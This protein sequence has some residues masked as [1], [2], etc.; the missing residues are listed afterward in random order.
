MKNRVLTF[1]ALALLAIPAASP[2]FLPDVPRTNDL[3]PHLFRAFFFDRAAEW[4]G[5]WPR[6]SPDLIY[7]YGYPVF[8]F[9]PSLFHAIT[10]TLSDFGLPLLTAYRV[11]TYLHFL[12]AAVGSYL[13]G[14]VALRSWAAG[15]AVALVYTYSPY[16]LYDAHVRG[17]A[18]ETQALALLP[19]LVLAIWKSGEGKFRISDFGFQRRASVGNWQ[20]A[21]DHWQ[22]FWPLATAVLFAATFISHPVVYQILIPMGLWL[23]LRAWFARK[24][25]RFWASL[26]GP[27]VGI[28]LG[29]LL[30]AFYWLPAFVEVGFVQAERSISQGYAHQ[31]NFLSLADML[32][33]PHLPAD[34]ALVNPPVVRALPLVGLPGRLILASRWQKMAR[35][36][37]EIVVTWTAVL[38]LCV[39]LITPASLFVWD[40]FPLLRLTFYPWR[41]LSMA[42]LATAILAGVA[43]GEIVNCELRIVNGERLIVN[44]QSLIVNFFLTVLIIAASIPWLYPPRQAMPERVDLPLA[45]REE[46]PPLF[47]GTT[48]LGE[49]LPQW[50]AELPPQEP[51]QSALIAQ[52]NP[53]RLQPAAGL[54]WTRQNENPVNAVYAVTATRPLTVTYGQFYFPGWRAW[55]DGDPRPITP[56]A[57]HGLI[58]IPVPEGDHEL[59]FAFGRTPARTAGWV[60]S[61]L[62]LAALLGMGYFGFR[63]SDFRVDHPKS[64]IP[65]PKFLLGLTAVLVWLFFT[66]VDTPLRRDTLLPDGV[67]GK[68]AMTPLDYAGELRLLTFEQSATAVAADEPIEL[69]LY[70]QPQREIGVP[71]DVGVQVLDAT[72]RQWQA[73]T[74]RPADWR[75]VGAEP[76]PLDSYRL[77]PF[78]VELADGTPPGDYTFHVGLVRGDTGQTVAAHDL[79]GFEVTRPANGARELE[80]GM[81][82]AGETAVARNLRLLGTRLDRDEAAPGD[83]ARVTALWQATAT[84][85]TPTNEFTL[86]LVGNGATV[87]NQPVTIAPDYPLADW[88][89]GDRLRSETILRL[90]A[91][92]ASGEYTWR[93]IWGDQDVAVGD[94]RVMAPERSFAPVAVETAVNA[95]FSDIATLLG[96]SFTPAPLLPH[97]PLLITLVWRAERET[98][99]SY[100]VFVHLIDEAGQ[101][102]AQSDGEPANWRRPTTGWLTGEIIVDEHV[103]TLP[104]SLP[105]GPLS[106]RIGLY[107]PVSGERLAADL[108]DFVVIPLEN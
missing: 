4:G 64:E 70:W 47:I 11:M 16:L 25:G 82:A 93:L 76:W 58:T 32:R 69:T 7:S 66:W 18:P 60:I 33:W 79:G 100:H 83:V 41:L 23:L 22:L 71:Y 86:Q 49:F 98:P 20:L 103:L 63:I 2:F 91:D 1:L 88:R 57:P 37:R 38:L 52:N 108:T 50:V 36:R 77:E 40:N 92:M 96:A 51:A 10:S 87:L 59:R 35:P 28:G 44:R 75:F 67:W 104:E 81:A 3:S 43:T 48:T 85:E 46:L 61:G 21:T 45:L 8:N 65:N 105:P 12:V 80:A 55:L 95:T 14:R 19:W 78:V 39:W 15:W 17:S 101:I 102:I 42:S 99:L 107:D 89:P 53:D 29:G 72:G 84:G 27:V 106:L 34:P 26:V 68:P 30:V 54:T 74:N 24:D 73:S 90:P 56:S 9:F 13:L 62:A 97:S 31:S 6:W 5:W 94:V